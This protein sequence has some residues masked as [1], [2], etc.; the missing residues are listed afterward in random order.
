[1]SSLKRILLTFFTAILSICTQA[2]NSFITDS[3]DQYVQREMK[4]WQVPGVAV[5][6]VKDGKVIVCK[7]YGVKSSDKKTSGNAVNEYT[8]FQIASNTKAFTATAI[9]LLDY[10]K[11]LMLDKPVTEY[12][13]SF[14]LYDPHA[15]AM[16]TVRDLLCHRIGLGTFQGDFYN[17]GSNLSRAEIIAGLGRTKPKYP[18]RYTYGYCNAAYITAGELIPLVTQQSWDDY[19]RLTFFEPMQLQHTN[20]SFEK[21]KSDTNACTPHTLYRGKL[22]TMPLTNIENMGPSA[23][24]NSC[25]A[26]MSKW[27]LLQLDSGK[28]NG[29]QVVPYRVLQ[30]TRKSHMIDGDIYSRFFTNKHF[31]NYG[32]GWNSY[33]YK[34][35]RFWEHS[36]GANGFVTKTEFCPELGL[37]VIVYTNSDANALYEALTKQIIESYLPITYRNIS[38]FYFERSKPM[39]EAENMQLDSLLKL[40]ASKPALPIKADAFEGKYKNELYGDMEIKREKGQLTVHLSHHPA[41]S[42]KLEY[43]GSNRFL[44]SWSDF[45]VGTETVSFE[46]EN[47]MVKSIDIKVNDFIDYEAYPFIKQ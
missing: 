35:Y 4:R 7:G 10:Q 40:A 31:S 5:A 19:L 29:K 1:M 42:G 17:W 34:G 44:L 20:T 2:Q 9:A 47:G 26:D 33:D 22:L 12:M 23:S 43:L 30:E 6:V 36:G 38:E 27:L 11:K 15:T 8:L 13:P 24:I 3:L 37:G 14:K 46:A 28:C 45:T 41:M 39:K 32:L 25:V 16:C 21:M 18:F